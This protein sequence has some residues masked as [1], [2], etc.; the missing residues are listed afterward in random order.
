MYRAMNFVTLIILVFTLQYMV[1]TV[2][3][4]EKDEEC[5]NL[6]IP[7]EMPADS[8]NNKEA[9]QA[10]IDFTHTYTNSYGTIT[11]IK[12]ERMF[13]SKGENAT[14]VLLARSYADLNPRYLLLH[15]DGIYVK[16]AMA[17]YRRFYDSVA[18]ETT[19]DWS[20]LNLNLSHEKGGFGSGRFSDNG[21]YRNGKFSYLY[22][23]IDISVI[24]SSI[25]LSDEPDSECYDNQFQT[26][27]V[28]PESES[29]TLHL[30]ITQRYYTSIGYSYSGDFKIR[31]HLLTISNGE[32]QIIKLSYSPQSSKFKDRNPRNL[33]IR[34]DAGELMIGMGK[35]METEI[36]YS[37][38]PWSY[39]AEWTCNNSSLMYQ[40][41]MKESPKLMFYKYYHNAGPATTIKIREE[42]LLFD[43][44]AGAV[45]E[46]SKMIALFVFLCTMN[47]FF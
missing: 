35:L 10:A 13:I 41:G 2:L 34:N 24:A 14:L 36:K 19:I 38:N 5:F 31:D 16:A 15:F 45:I 18:V 26:L 17:S 6:D 30:N 3:A 23:I 40:P 20:C 1:L 37:T 43:V 33:T 8:R 12:Q 9:I 44:S 21:D 47:V 28:S 7:L 22:D 32:Q 39:K 42:Y 25:P 27:M 11:T 4:H 29:W 46:L